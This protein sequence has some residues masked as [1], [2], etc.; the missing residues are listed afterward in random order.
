MKECKRRD[1]TSIRYA[2]EVGGRIIYLFYPSYLTASNSENGL[3]IN[4]T[5]VNPDAPNEKNRIQKII[6]QKYPCGANIRT[7]DPEIFEE[8][9]E[10]RR[11]LD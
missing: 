7:D 2:W 11:T 9:G 8:S 3:K 1:T 4:I 5:D 10:G 6:D